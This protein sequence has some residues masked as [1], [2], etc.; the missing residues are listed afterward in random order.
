MTKGSARGGWGWNLVF[1]LA[2]LASLVVTAHVGRDSMAVTR[3]WARADG[4]I[5]GA[6]PDP[7]ASL[8]GDAVLYRPVVEFRDASGTPH[9]NSSMLGADQSAERRLG[10]R[11]PLYYLPSDPSRAVVA[12]FGEQWLTPVLGLAA[13]IF[14][15]SFPLWSRRLGAAGG[16]ARSA[17]G[18]R[19]WMALQL[20]GLA[21]TVVGP[22]M[23]GISP[24][25]VERGQ[26]LLVATAAVTGLVL[27]WMGRGETG[28]RTQLVA[29]ALVF[30]ALAILYLVMIRRIVTDEHPFGVGLGFAVVGLGLWLFVH[31]PELSTGELEGIVV[32][33]LSGTMLYYHSLHRTHA[34]ESVSF[35]ALALSLLGLGFG[36]WLLRDRLK[37]LRWRRPRR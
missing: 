31:R 30:A 26:L 23:V 10:R 28:F 17:P 18:G 22:A 11:V 6:E 15:G 32:A 7:A 16:A 33:T 29:T 27:I 12:S 3:D 37:E 1:V 35:E 2:G 34:G 13:G 8:L 9:R 21:F 20:V 36:R 5:V 24:F 25:A 14:L 4:T 19:G